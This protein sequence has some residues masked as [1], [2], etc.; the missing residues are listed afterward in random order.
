MFVRFYDVVLEIFVDI[1]GF[2]CDFMFLC[3]VYDLGGG[4]EFYGLGI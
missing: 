3:I 2:D 4:I 1:D